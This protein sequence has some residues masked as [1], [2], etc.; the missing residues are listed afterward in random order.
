MVN[1]TK[2]TIL[3]MQGMRIRTTTIDDVR[4]ISEITPH[5]YDLTKSVIAEIRTLN[6]SVTI[7]SSNGGRYHY[8]SFAHFMKESDKFTKAIFK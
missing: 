8:S 2:V 5:N 3:V 4:N 7:F 6:G 1:L